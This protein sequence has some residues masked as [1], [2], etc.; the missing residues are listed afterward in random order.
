MD[1]AAQLPRHPTVDEPAF[2]PRLGHEQQR[3]LP[4]LRQRGI[5]LTV[6]PLYYMTH[7]PE[8]ALFAAKKPPLGLALDLC[9]H[10]RQLPFD[11]RAKQPRPDRKHDRGSADERALAVAA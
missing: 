1:K 4:A 3:L 6:S 9:A 5:R 10:H 8:L 2:V 7:N 11:S